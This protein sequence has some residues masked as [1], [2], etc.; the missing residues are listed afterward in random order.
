MIVE[1]PIKTSLCWIL[2]DKFK[3]QIRSSSLTRITR[4][5]ICGHS[6][7]PL[8]VAARGELSVGSALDL[9]SISHITGVLLNETQATL[10]EVLVE[11][12]LA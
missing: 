5:H 7:S 8:A 12:Q 9:D 10:D 6:T 1:V 11:G 4:K 3:F 2:T